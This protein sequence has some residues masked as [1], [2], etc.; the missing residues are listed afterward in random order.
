MLRWLNKR[1]DEMTLV[2]IFVVACIVIFLI[3]T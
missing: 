1:G 3:R 2:G